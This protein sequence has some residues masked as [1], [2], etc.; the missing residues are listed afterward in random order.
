MST[1]DP[2]LHDYYQQTLHAP[3]PQPDAAPALAK[4]GRAG[5]GRP[6][7]RARR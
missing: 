7:R 4:L 6:P 5:A 1:N 2:L 3:W